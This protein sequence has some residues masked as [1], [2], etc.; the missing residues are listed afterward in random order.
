MRC[1]ILGCPFAALLMVSVSTSL[2]AGQQGLVGHWR[3][4][5][6]SGAVA[7]DSSGSGNHGEIVGAT[8][9]KRGEGHALRFDEETD[10]V[11]IAAD[12]SLDIGSAGT[13]SLWFY[14]D[15]VR[16]G[17][18]SYGTKGEL[19]SRMRLALGFD[20]RTP[21]GDPG[22]EL[23]LWAGNGRTRYTQPITDPREG[24][25]NHVGLTIA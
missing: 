16:G 19:A 9:V 25:W 5:E 6:G 21:W 15:E 11:E 24:D 13:I 20:T 2:A 17:L 1:G 8:F 14:P 18:F 12:P 10:L 4:D 23:R 3:F 7:R 22:N